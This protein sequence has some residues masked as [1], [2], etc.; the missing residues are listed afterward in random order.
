LSGFGKWTGAVWVEQFDMIAESDEAGKH[1]QF[2]NSGG[3][4]LMKR[5]LSAPG[6]CGKL[7][8]CRLT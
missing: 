6:E 2:G 1:R 8:F 5:F 3:V 7:L 4:L